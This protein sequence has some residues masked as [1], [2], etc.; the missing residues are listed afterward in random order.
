MWKMVNKSAFIGVL[1]MVLV[2]SMPKV[3]ALPLI[4]S[5]FDGILYDIDL[6]TGA[7][8]NP[9]NT[10][11]N[12]LAGI[13]FSA[14]GTLYGLSTFGNSPNPNSLF[15]V[16]PRTGAS[17]LIG[18]TGIEVTEGG[19]A[20][21]PT[22]E[23]LYGCQAKGQDLLYTF[24]LSNAKATVKGTIVSSGDISA[25]SFDDSGTLYAI[26][27][28]EQSLLTLDPS[29]ANIIK[30]IDLNI[31]L[32]SILGMDFD[33]SSGIMYVADGS[34]GGTDTLY[35]VDLST[36]VLSPVGPTGLTDGLSG[37]AIVPEPYT[38]SLLGLGSFLVLKKRRRRT[39]N[40]NY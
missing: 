37:L 31:S 20:F 18:I 13:E 33:P 2:C 3:Q 22:S 35:T 6:L 11:I 27:Q 8:S 32:G 40:I 16:D 29:N 24:D 15:R 39:I 5:D 23:L 12:P 19:L 28:L 26:D 14:D 21:D 38:I 10:G 1:V 25:I 4:G 34:S 30:S 7:V 9:R 36:G 17:T